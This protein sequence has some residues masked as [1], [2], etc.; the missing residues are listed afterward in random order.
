MTNVEK[1]NQIRMLRNSLGALT[2]QAE[3]VSR[4]I[5]SRSSSKLPRKEPPLDKRI[6]KY[7]ERIQ[8]LR[9]K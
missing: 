4:V 2:T 5:P 8:Q 7:E 9:H 1:A 6:Q 3:V